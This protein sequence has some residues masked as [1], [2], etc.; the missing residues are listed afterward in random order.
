VQTR[1]KT[2]QRATVSSRVPFVPASDPRKNLRDCRLYPNGQ[3]HGFPFSRSPPHNPAAVLHQH[4]YLTGD[5]LEICDWSII[6]LFVVE[7]TS[8]LYLAKNMW[9][10][11]RSPWHLVDLVIIVLPFVQYL[12]FSA[13]VR[14]VPLP[15][16]SR[17]LRLPRALAV[18]GRA[19]GSRM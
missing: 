16:S 2:L 17:V 5:F 11:F 14:L 10:H 9:A 19:L 8:K 3:V 6:I 4:L 13:S 15:F 12:R 18:G 1:R 7:Y